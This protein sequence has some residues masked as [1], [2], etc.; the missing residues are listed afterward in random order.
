MISIA[1]SF[2]AKVQFLLNFPPKKIY[3]YFSLKVDIEDS[4]SMNYIIL[5]P[6]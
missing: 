1:G 2:T 3:P 6:S 4:A 5:A